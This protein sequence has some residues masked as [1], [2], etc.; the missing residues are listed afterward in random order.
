MMLTTKQPVHYG[1]RTVHDLPTP[2]RS[3]PPVTVQD[4]IQK[5]IP[6]LS[7]K[8]SPSIKPMSGPHRGLPP[9][10]AMTLPQPPVP[11]PIHQQAPAGP[12]L[13]TQAPQA[14][15]PPPHSHALAPLPPPPHS[16]ESM[17][18]WLIAKAEE[19]KRKQQ[20]ERTRQETL[21]LEQRKLEFD[22]LRTSLERGVPPQ[23]VPIV[24]AGMGGG[25]LPQAF[26]EYAQQYIVPQASH[27]PQSLPAPGAVS[28]E[29]RRDSQYGLYSG[30]SAAVA[31][32]PGS[33]G[34]L[35]AGFITYQGPGSPTRPRAHTVMGGP[36]GRPVTG[37]NLPRLN[38][39]EPASGSQNPPSYFRASNPAQQQASSQQEQSPSI[40]FHHW[41]PPTSQA[42]SNQPG[43]PS[44]SSQFKKSM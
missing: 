3:S 20:E 29:H 37:S 36:V 30:S 8:H 39:E 19:E 2:P 7:Q 13:H 34:G 28:P 21:R 38:T 40:Y 23:L 10:A 22:M 26:L 18:N 24:F 35:Q 42:S 17:R 33:G 43:T 16:D 44:G 12:P 15:Q 9:P 27:A 41:Q 5:T 4:P 25:Q 6:P 31:S 32:T 1:Y 14:P 11:G